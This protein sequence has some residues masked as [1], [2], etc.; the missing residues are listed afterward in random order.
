VGDDFTIMQALDRP[1]WENTTTG[2]I[3]EQIMKNEIKGPY[4][5]CARIMNVNWD[6]IWNGLWSNKIL[7]NNE[8]ELYF[9][10][11]H[12]AVP[13]EHIQMDAR[14]VEDVWKMHTI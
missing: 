6:S 5:V 7:Y 9:K 8:K 10:L 1:K 3:Y 14:C 12:N 11:I 2:K 4:T 13:I